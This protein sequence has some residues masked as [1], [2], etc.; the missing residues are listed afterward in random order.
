MKIKKRFINKRNIAMAIFIVIFVVCISEIFSFASFDKRIANLHIKNGVL[1]LLKWDFKRDGVVEL[2][3]HWKFYWNKLVYPED[4]INSNV[5]MTGLIK[6]S[7]VWNGLE[8]GNEKLK[9]KGFATYRLKII[10]G[11]RNENISLKL[12]NISTSYNLYINGELVANNGVVGKDK[13]STREEEETIVV[14]YDGDEPTL[15]LLLQV[16]NFKRNKGGVK[17]NILIGSQEDIEG[18]RNRGIFL[19]VFLVASILIMAFYHLVIY[20]IN[21][22]K[23]S[24]ICFSLF[25]FSLA[26]RILVTGEKRIS[27]IFPNISWSH[28]IKIEY[29]SF[30]LAVP[31]FSVSM[32]YMFKEQ[33]S[34][35]ALKI[36]LTI[37]S[38]FS[39]VVIINDAAVFTDTLILFQV[40]T[41]ITGMYIAYALIKAY[42]CKVEGAGIIII[43]HIVLLLTSI[44]DILHSNG[45]IFTRHMSPLGVILVVFIQ[46]IVLGQNILKSLIRT[47]QLVKENEEMVDEITKLNL[48]LEKRNEDLRNAAIHDKLT[49]VY[50]RG[51]Y[52]TVINR[53]EAEKVL[54]V[55]II[56]GDVNGLKLVNDAFGH[57]KGDILIKKVVNILK[58]S[59]RKQDIIARIGGDEFAIILQGNDDKAAE[60]IVKDIRDK[61]DK[62]EDYPIKPS[63]SLGY[64]V[65]YTKEQ[66]MKEILKEADDY[67]YKIKLLE[68]KNAHNS[69]M[70]SL[71]KTLEKTTYETGK[72]AKRLEALSI[73]LGKRLNLSEN[74][75]NDLLLLA[76]LHDIGKIAIPMNILNKPGKLTKA[77]WNV[78]KRHA[79]IGYH[80]ANSSSELRGIGQ[81]ILSHHERWDGQGYPRKLAGKQI[82]LLARIIS[83]ADSFDAMTQNR[84]YHRG[85]SKREAL[86]EMKRCAGTQFDPLIVEKFIDMMS[87]G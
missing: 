55:S 70:H 78:V 51:Y 9:S 63:I 75:L 48:R 39:I 25:C 52:E 6:V 84:S 57:A 26:S 43:G 49:G 24:Y 41:F 36:I 16:S 22:K 72:H 34:K 71:E 35:R 61:C 37:T 83:V 10:L 79:E 59:C 15:D 4:L 33:F 44:N 64:S 5:E 58:S 65:R 68:S 53:L 28:M 46:A 20:L 8:I 62:A 19:D 66:S 7:S 31:A 42:I 56:I 2:S 27:I 69:I 77:E 60:R 67:M 85:I 21:R 12:S 47:E 76:R 13:Y 74:D 38:I 54:P 80:I 82:P 32:Y 1:N 45:L 86:E 23:L 17:D 11:D 3:G 40:C 29:L 87:E 30:Y 73:K 18:I 50:N 81:S 14:N